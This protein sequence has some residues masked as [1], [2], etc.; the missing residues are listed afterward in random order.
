M[1]THKASIAVWYI[2]CIF[3]FYSDPNLNIA[4][5]NILKMLKLC[6][7]SLTIMCHKLTIWRGL[8][9]RFRALYVLCACRWRWID[10]AYQMGHTYEI[11][12]SFYLR[13]FTLFPKPY[14]FCISENG[15]SIGERICQ[16]IAKNLCLVSQF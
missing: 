13:T 9:T 3:P 2:S 1:R 7:E 14:L 15:N 6:L 12:S 10:T 5:Q 4:F 16:S 11:V 8:Y